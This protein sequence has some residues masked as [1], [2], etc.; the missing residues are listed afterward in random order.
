MRDAT[1]ISS[2]LC[3]GGQPWTNAE[4]AYNRQCFADE[5][6]ICCDPAVAKNFL[7]QEQKEKIS[8][9]M[10]RTFEACYTALVQD[11]VWNSHRLSRVEEINPHQE[12]RTI[13][14]TPK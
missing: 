2:P 9:R 4:E 8:F 1:R 6:V 11:S 12:T 13:G 14:R 3:R 7:S 5:G 10:Q